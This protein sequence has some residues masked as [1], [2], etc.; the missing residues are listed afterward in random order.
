MAWDPAVYQ[1]FGDQR[2]RPFRD[3]LAHVGATDPARVVDLGC[4]SGALTATLAQ[5]WPGAQVLGVDASP[6]MLAEARPGPRLD[7]RLGD[8]ADWDPAADGADVVVSN[9][10]LQWVP[11]HLAMLARWAGALPSGGWLAFQVPANFAA[12]SH[13]LMRETAQL[14]RWR[15]RLDGVLRHEGAVEAL[16]TY[17]RILADAGCRVDAWETSYLHVLAGENPVLDWVRGT[18]LRPVLAA[19]GPEGAAFE[20]QYAARLR[21]AYPATQHGTVFAFLRRFVVAWKR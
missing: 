18:G 4:G 10:A 7:F 1:G 16:E 21:E 11:G 3:L 9:A 20:E 2:A 8:I 6:E 5:R 19:L 15:S 14:P 13:Q 17:W 12:P